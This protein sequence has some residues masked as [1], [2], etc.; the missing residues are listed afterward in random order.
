MPL[1]SYPA[2][3]RK[4]RRILRSR[5]SARIPARVAGALAYSLVGEAAHEWI[6]IAMLALFILIG[7]LAAKTLSKAK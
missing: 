6:G 2:P 3:M 4:Y 5:R 7:F 1:S